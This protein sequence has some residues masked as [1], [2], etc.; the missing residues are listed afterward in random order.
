MENYILF[1]VII[2]IIVILIIV[3]F[4]LQDNSVNNYEEVERSGC[5]STICSE[6]G[7]Q[8]VKYRCNSSRCRRPNGR[9]SSDREYSVEIPCLPPCIQSQWDVLEDNDRFTKYICMLHDNQGRNN[10]LL[11]EKQNLTMIGEFVRIGRGMRQYSIGSIYIQP[12]ALNVSID[13]EQSKWVSKLPGNNGFTYNCSFIQENVPLETCLSYE[14]GKELEEQMSVGFIYVPMT[15]ATVKSIGEGDLKEGVCHRTLEK[16]N[17]NRLTDE[18]LILIKEAMDDELPLRTMDD[19]GKPYCIQKCMK[20]KRER[21]GELNPLMIEI[22]SVFLTMR[23]KTRDKNNVLIKRGNI[24]AVDINRMQEM[25]R[26]LN[27]A[28]FCNPYIIKYTSSLIFLFRPIESTDDYLIGNLFAISGEMSIGFID[29]NFRWVYYPLTTEQP[30]KPEN[31]MFVKVT[32]NGNGTYKIVNYKTGDVIT[33]PMILT[34]FQGNTSVNTS[35]V[36]LSLY[37]FLERLI[38]VRR[39]SRCSLHQYMKY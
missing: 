32:R 38:S 36:K 11:R 12:K 20:F 37:P 27:I 15:C 8:I 19:E 14:D 3:A 21:L 5:S 34:T 9:I 25:K 17:I 7:V 35:E 1:I 26:R 39:G 13:T 16:I 33:I 10:C 29:E 18:D 4:I 2:I 24:V 28:E 6:R 31:I 22:G 30:K 23:G